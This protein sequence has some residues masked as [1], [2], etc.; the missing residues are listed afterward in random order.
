MTRMRLRRPT[1]LMGS[2]QLAGCSSNKGRLWPC[3]MTAAH[4]L[5]DDKS[6]QHRPLTC[7][8]QLR[9]SA[10]RGHWPRP[11]HAYPTGWPDN[12]LTH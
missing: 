8:Q 9:L 6:Q 7:D 12:I 5:T 10:L 11:S 2:S 4:A 3:A 1:I